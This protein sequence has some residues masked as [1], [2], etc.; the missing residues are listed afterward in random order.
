MERA[1][2]F[3]WLPWLHGQARRTQRSAGGGLA[4]WEGGHDGYRRL[5]QPVDHR[6]G[7][8]RLPE[9]TWLVV[10]RLHSEGVHSYRLHWLLPDLAYTWQTDPAQL[11][12]QTA[13]GPY[14]MRLAALAQAGVAT[15]VRADERSA[16]GWRAPYYGYREP[17]LSLDVTVEGASVFFW[18]LFSPRLC[19]VADPDGDLTLESDHWQT[20]IRLRGS[21]QPGLLSRVALTG[22]PSDTLEI[23]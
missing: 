14:H 22:M 7:I 4:Y 15:L 9:D 5:R 21:E 13:A 10:D 16:R 1:G 8:L 3:L 23:S 6:R 12:L 17:A 19:Q 11:M 20:Q 2:R 18:T